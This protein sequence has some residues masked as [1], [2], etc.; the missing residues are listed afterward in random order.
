M[1]AITKEQYNE[2]FLKNQKIALAEI[3]EVIN[4]NMT[5]GLKELSFS[6]NHLS[7]DSVRKLIEMYSEAGW[8][9][10]HPPGI[11]YFY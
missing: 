10:K 3:I 2:V 6:I 7:E 9:V 4:S 1:R 11:I 8:T 5:K